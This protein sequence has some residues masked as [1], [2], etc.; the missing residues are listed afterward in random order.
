L[1][2]ST[3][4]AIFEGLLITDLFA[5]QGSQSAI[6][7]HEGPWQALLLEI[8]EDCAQGRYPTAARFGSRL[9]QLELQSTA[10]CLLAALPLLLVNI[11]RYG[12][13]HGVL[14]QWARQM[15]VSAFISTALDELFVGLCQIQAGGGALP[16]LPS[17]QFSGKSANIPSFSTPCL[18]AV[19]GLVAQSQWQFGLCLQLAQ[20]HRWAPADMGLI[21]LF[22]PLRGGVAAIPLALRQKLWNR[23]S[24]DYRGLGGWSMVEQQRL[25]VLSH[26][27]YDRWGGITPS[28]H[29]SKEIGR[30]SIAIT[31]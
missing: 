5:M 22:A 20:Q 11:D 25:M 18:A 12:H 13:R 9:R 26:E 7:K 17:G 24:D 23:L 29:L 3:F 15:G 16:Y 21:A 28:A 2:I 10:G 4:N 27:L 31:I 14:R 1:R 6:S 8:A 30:G 19:Y